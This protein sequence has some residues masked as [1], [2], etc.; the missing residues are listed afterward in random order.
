MLKDGTKYLAKIKVG[1][2]IRWDIVSWGAFAM[3]VPKKDGWINQIGIGL[4]VDSIMEFHPLN[5]IIASLQ[6]ESN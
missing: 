1:N 4:K 3:V 5:D 2:S 6:H